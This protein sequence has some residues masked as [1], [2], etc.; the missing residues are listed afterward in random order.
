MNIKNQVLVQTRQNRVSFFSLPTYISFWWLWSPMSWEYPPRTPPFST[1]TRHWSLDFKGPRWRS[2]SL[3]REILCAQ[4][5]ISWNQINQTKNG[6]GAWPKKK[7]R[8]SASPH[9]F[10]LLLF[11]F[12]PDV[13][14]LVVGPPLWKIWKS[15]GMMTFPIYGKIKVM[16]QSP[17]TSYFPW[18]SSKNALNL[19][20][21]RQVLEPLRPFNRRRRRHRRL[22]PAGPSPVA[23][24][25]ASTAARSAR[26]RRAASGR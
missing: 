12:S 15:I 11:G 17:P 3:H 4:N 14:W 22:R 9:V 26:V 1:E 24:S 8:P 5:G 21:P 19:A 2:A 13:I 25:V 6:L 20:K 7:L 23:S 18:R 16:F 10:L